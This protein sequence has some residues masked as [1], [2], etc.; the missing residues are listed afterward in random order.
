MEEYVHAFA[1]AWAELERDAGSRRVQLERAL[2]DA[3]R[4]LHGMVRAIEGGSW[5]DAIKT[6]LHELEN[7]KAQLKA[8]LAALDA[9]A[10]VRLHPNAAAMY[11]RQI[12]ELE[13]ALNAD[14][15]RTEAAEA[16]RTLIDQ[17]V[18]TPDPMAPDGLAA[19][20]RGDLAEILA[21][22]AAPEAGTRRRKGTKNSPER[23]FAG[24]QLSV[25]AGARNHLDL[26]LTA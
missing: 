5:S 21:L 7:R 20:L 22:A 13:A 6:R 9:P 8:D 26:L 25:V 17:V 24:G 11:A 15:I 2:A 1:E 18:L 4:G 16:L 3:E 12:A 19:E 14:D 23:V 10:P